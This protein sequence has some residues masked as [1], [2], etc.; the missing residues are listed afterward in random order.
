MTVAHTATFIAWAALDFKEGHIKG[1][2]GGEMHAWR[3]RAV[4]LGYTTLEMVAMVLP[5]IMS[6]W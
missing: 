3:R 6:H 1:E 4:M 2:W 5:A